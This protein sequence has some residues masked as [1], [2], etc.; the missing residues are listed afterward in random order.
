MPGGL[1]V[2]VPAP[3]PARLVLSVGPL[4]LNVA[5]TEALLVKLNEQAP[6]PLHAPD[7]PVNV[8][9]AFGVAVSVTEVPVLNSALHTVPQLMPAGLLV[10]VPLPERVTVIAGDTEAAVNIAVTEVLP[11]K[12]NLQGPVPLQAP[13]QPAKVELAAGVAVRLTE[14]SMLNAALQVVPQLM[15]AGLLVTVPLPV[16]ER[17]RL[18]TG[19]LANVAETVMLE[20]RVTLQLFDPLHAPPQFTNADPGFAVSVNV[21]EVPPGKLLLQVVPQLMPPGLLTTVPLPLACTVS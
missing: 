4:S 21:T 7:H 1:L 3:G 19:E 2:I 20:F 8:D 10:T 6:I 16:P 13:L 9:P 12:F 5:V 14:V 18:K 15:P 17:M 11:L